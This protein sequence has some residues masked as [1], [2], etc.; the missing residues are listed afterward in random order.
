MFA[1][2]NIILKKFTSFNLIFKNFDVI[3]ESF[4]PM[5]R[6]IKMPINNYKKL[7]VCNYKKLTI[8]LF[9]NK[10]KIE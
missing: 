3:F 9:Y 2:P 8:Y 1:V 4:F 7:E 5:W 6:T 10:N